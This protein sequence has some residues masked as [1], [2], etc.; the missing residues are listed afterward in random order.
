METLQAHGRGRI[1]DQKSQ[2]HT[3]AELDAGLLHCG[4][5]SGHCPRSQARDSQT[6]VLQ[7]HCPVHTPKTR[8]KA[9]KWMRSVAS[10]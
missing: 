5:P 8:T 2:F 4:H 10:V 6:R 9:H 3:E 7:K 1:L